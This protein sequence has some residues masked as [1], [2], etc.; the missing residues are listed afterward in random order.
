MT[1]NL[2]G[3]ERMGLTAGEAGGFA[4]WVRAGKVC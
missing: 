2:P 3:M 1:W 4:L